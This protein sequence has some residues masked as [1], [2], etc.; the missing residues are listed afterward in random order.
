[1][2]LAYKHT[3]ALGDL[4]RERKPDRKVYC[5]IDLPPSDSPLE[6]APTV[7]AQRT[8][9]LSIEPELIWESYVFQYCDRPTFCPHCHA[10]IWPE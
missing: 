2:T 3:L 6:E 9:N 10:A 5:I 1:M 4:F 8:D 7:L